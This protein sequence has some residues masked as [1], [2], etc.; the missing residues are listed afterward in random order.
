MRYY[1]QADVQ[2]AFEVD[3]DNEDQAKERVEEVLALWVPNHVDG[4]NNAEGSSEVVRV[5]VPT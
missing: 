4:A 1:I 5:R 2:W 3:A